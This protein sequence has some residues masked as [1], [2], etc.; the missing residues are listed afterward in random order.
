MGR[1]KNKYFKW[2]GHILRLGDS[3]WTKQILIG[4]QKKEKG[5]GGRPEIK[6]DNSAKA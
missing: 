3:R 4:R 5:R 1:I 6:S 2:C